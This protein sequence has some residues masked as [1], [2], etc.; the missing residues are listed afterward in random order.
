VTADRIDS[1][2]TRLAELDAE[3][4]RLER[5]LRKLE[6]A[7]KPSPEDIVKGIV[8]KHTDQGFDDLS[9]ADLSWRIV[10]MNGRECGKP[11]IDVRVDR[12]LLTLEE[13]KIVGARLG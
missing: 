4:G 5:E 9:S 2:K 12:A 7:S 8:G 11:P 3:R 1:I 13:E 6:A 10:K